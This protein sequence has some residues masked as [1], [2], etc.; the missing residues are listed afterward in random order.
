MQFASQDPALQD[1]LHGVVMRQARSVIMDPYANAFNI[2]NNGAGH[3]DDPRRPP[4]TKGVY[5][6][7]NKCGLDCDTWGCWCSA[8]LRHQSIGSSPNRSPAS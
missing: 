1:M 3:Q 5:E 6:V 8:C 2:D 4:M 7:G